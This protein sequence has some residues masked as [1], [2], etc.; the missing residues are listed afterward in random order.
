MLYLPNPRWTLTG[1]V[2]EKVFHLYSM[3]GAE[4]VIISPQSSDA[5]RVEALKFLTSHRELFIQNNRNTSLRSLNWNGIPVGYHLLETVPHILGRHT[6]DNVEFFNISV[7]VLA[8][9]GFWNRFFSSN[10]VS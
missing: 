7:Y 5:D 6:I 8:Q 3:L 10:S 2:L 4:N 1:T 9:I